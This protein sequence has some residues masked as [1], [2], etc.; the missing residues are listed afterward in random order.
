MNEATSASGKMADYIGTIRMA[1]E[2][3]V[4]LAAQS[5]CY[6]VPI[7]PMEKACPQS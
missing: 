4:S 1:R 6:T 3:R 5:P 7:P 2:A